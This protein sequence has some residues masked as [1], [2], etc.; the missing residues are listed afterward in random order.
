MR[1]APRTITNRSKEAR[2]EIWEVTGDRGA[3]GMA[4]KQNFPTGGVFGRRGWDYGREEGGGR[5]T[6]KREAFAGRKLSS[7]VEGCLEEE[8]MGEWKKGK[9]CPEC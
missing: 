2:T 5:M 8:V 7:P 3:Q 9:R 1:F 6:S 4:Y